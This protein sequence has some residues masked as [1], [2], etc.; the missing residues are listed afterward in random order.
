MADESTFMEQEDFN[1][2]SDVLKKLFESKLQGT[3]IGLL[4]PIFGRRMVLTG[5][6]DLILDDDPIVV[7]KPYDM[8]GYILPETKIHLKEIHS[9]REFI[10]KFKN[11]F[12]KRLT[13]NGNLL[14][15]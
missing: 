7:L 11:P 5:V 8:H 3:I 12:E 9:V 14:L 1:D 6:E 15:T 2:P 10:S 4:S 13:S